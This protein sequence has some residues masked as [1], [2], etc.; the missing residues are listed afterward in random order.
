MTTADPLT[1]PRPTAPSDWVRT[2]SDLRREHGFEPLRVEGTLPA[3]LEGTFYK[4]GPGRFSAGG[5]RYGH[6]FDG[7]GAVTGV[8][9]KGGRASGG[10]RLVRT[11]AFERQERSARPLYGGYNTRFKRP[12]REAMLRNGKNAANTSVMLWQGR[13]FALCEA[14]K[15]FEIDRET[16]GTAGERDLGG[17]LTT[18][19]SAHPHDVPARRASYNFGIGPSGPRT[20]R[21]AA[22]EL[23]YAGR[24]RQ[25]VDFL[26]PGPTLVH[27]FAVTE[28]HLVFSIAPMTLKLLPILLGRAGAMDALEWR[29]ERGGEL[30]VVPIDDP[31]ATFRIATDAYLCE[32]VANAFERGDT[33]HL[34]FTRY[35]DMR[36]LEDYV[37]GVADGA[38]RAPLEGSLCRA[39]ID[40]HAR[41]VRF[42]DRLVT[43]CELPRVSPRVDALP[44]RF[45]YLA[46]YAS[47][48]D[49]RRFFNMVLKLDVER[50]TVERFPFPAGHFCSEALFVPRTFGTAEDDGYL[51]SMAYDAA[52]DRSYLAVL[53]AKAPEAPA[54]ARVYF[55]HNIP[56]G[57]H[58]LWSAAASA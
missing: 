44:H 29:S 28:R 27:D 12:F 6:W 46:G 45:I 21:V 1:V 51:L 42:E 5:E 32:H 20:S 4:N 18:A 26:V 57:F 10:V 16:L 15:P 23:P 38:V 53:D 37:G 33:L 56:P 22:Y 31:S 11:P 24:A 13:L 2:F 14:G 19:F 30:V 41:R 35:A 58:A 36:A 25:I 34:D 39:V 54:R 8:R 49:A 9:L 50:G 3:D 17:V 47:P 52:G 7:D 55:D 48:A 40:L 43:P